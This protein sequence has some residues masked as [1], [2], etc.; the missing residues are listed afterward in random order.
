MFSEINYFK[1]NIHYVRN[2]SFTILGK[3]LVQWY[4]QPLNNKWVTI[5]WVLC[6][7]L[8][9]LLRKF[10]HQYFVYI[11]KFIIYKHMDANKPL[12]LMKMSCFLIDEK[13]NSTVKF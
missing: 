8:Y 2:Q 6:L 9:I 11:I 10:F 4:R 1:G 5:M 13:T 12:F 3:L 7:Y